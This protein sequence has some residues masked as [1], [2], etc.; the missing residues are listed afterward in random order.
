MKLIDHPSLKHAQASSAY[1]R[2]TKGFEAKI[3]VEGMVEAAQELAVDFSSDVLMLRMLMNTKNY[4]YVIDFAEFCKVL[5][6]LQDGEDLDDIGLEMPV[7]GKETESAARLGS[8]T[9][10]TMQEETPQTLI[11]KDVEPAVMMRV[12]LSKEA[13][14]RRPDLL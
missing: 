12:V 6:I 1:E 10:P 9:G 5:N 7:L 13:L 8:P 14:S 2:L 4:D 11:D 3:P